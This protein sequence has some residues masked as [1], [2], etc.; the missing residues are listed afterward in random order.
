MSKVSSSASLEWIINGTFD[1]GCKNTSVDN[2]NGM[3]IGTG[4]QNTLDIV[5][6]IPFMHIEAFSIIFFLSFNGISKSKR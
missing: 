3:T 2:A 6:E 5:N 1:W 4:Y